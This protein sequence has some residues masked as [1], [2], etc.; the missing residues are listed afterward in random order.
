M[1]TKVFGVLGMDG[2][3]E[4]G[5]GMRG[6]ADFEHARLLKIHTSVVVSARSVMEFSEFGPLV[7]L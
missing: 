7:Y 6:D 4:G 2:T 1:I 5:W 3:L